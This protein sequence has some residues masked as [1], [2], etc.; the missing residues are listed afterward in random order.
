MRQ[1]HRLPEQPLASSSELDGP[2]D[3]SCFRVPPPE[4]SFPGQW[5]KPKFPL[6]VKKAY[7]CRILPCLVTKATWILLVRRTVVEGQVHR[8][9]ILIRKH[10]AV[11]REVQIVAVLQEVDIVQLRVEDIAAV[12]DVRPEPW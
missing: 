9:Y 11:V 6:P 12:L 5:Q 2:S 7:P 4:E 3:P 1:T 8:S 10:Y